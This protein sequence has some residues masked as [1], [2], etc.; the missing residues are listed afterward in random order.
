[1]IAAL[2]AANSPTPTTHQRIVRAPPRLQVVAINQTRIA[3][4]IRRR[5][6]RRKLSTLCPSIAHLTIAYPTAS[7]LNRASAPGRRHIELFPGLDVQRT[8]SDIA[9]A[10]ALA[11]SKIGRDP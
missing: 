10:A 9:A 6:L 4:T 3:R 8:S 7:M 5:S 11:A 1:M 2:A